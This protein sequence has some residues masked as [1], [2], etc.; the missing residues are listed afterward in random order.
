MQYA[1]FVDP[2]RKYFFCSYGT[3][4]L[5]S[6]HPSMSTQWWYSKSLEARVKVIRSPFM[7]LYERVAKQWACYHAKLVL[8]FI[9]EAF[10][11]LPLSSLHIT[12]WM[13]NREIQQ[14]INFSTEEIDPRDFESLMQSSDFQTP[15]Y[16]VHHLSCYEIAQIRALCLLSLTILLKGIPPRQNLC[17]AI[18]HGLRRPTIVVPYLK[19]L[20]IV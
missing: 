4:F 19:D 15:V 3:W 14:S 16:H 11:M 8:F 18:A 5:T 17:F 20:T 2:N 13:T 12:A 10:P 1:G 7:E 6:K 9:T